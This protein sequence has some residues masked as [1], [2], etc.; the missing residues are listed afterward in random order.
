MFLVSQHLEG[1]QR[2][3][4][5]RQLYTSNLR[6]VHF[7]GEPFERTFARTEDTTRAHLR[8]HKHSTA[9]INVEI[10]LNSCRVTDSTEGVGGHAQLFT[11]WLNSGQFSCLIQADFRARMNIGFGLFLHLTLSY[12]KA[13]IFPRVHQADLT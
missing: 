3:P 7:T 5:F 8:N 13:D 1:K 2:K 12:I 6:V 9:G 10:H 11:H 4:M